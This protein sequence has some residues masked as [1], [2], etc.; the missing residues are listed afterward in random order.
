MPKGAPQQCVDKEQFQI[1]RLQPIYNVKLTF[2]QKQTLRQN[3]KFNL[4]AAKKN[5][6]M[7]C[8]K[9]RATFLRVCLA[10]LNSNFH[11]CIQQR[12]SLSQTTA[13]PQRRGTRRNYHIC[14]Y[15]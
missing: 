3:E 14:C 6:Y 2:T 1:K 8:A 9:Y 10:H 12:T 13:G 4:L 5:F 15:C 11:P 7:T